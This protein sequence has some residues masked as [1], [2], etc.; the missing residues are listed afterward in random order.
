[1]QQQVTV[2]CLLVSISG[3][4]ANLDLPGHMERIVW[5][6]LK[7]WR[8]SERL[9]IQ[10]KEDV[11]NCI[12]RS[13]EICTHYQFR[14]KW[15]CQ[16]GQDETPWV[17]DE[18]FKQNFSWKVRMVERCSLVHTDEDD[19]SKLGNVCRTFCRIRCVIREYSKSRASLLAF[20]LTWVDK[21][22]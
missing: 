5:Q 10:G 1:M 2:L 7:T 13:F 3:L 9:N 21:Y 16:E 17:L 20:A 11:E 14:V 8:R 18:K 19:I 15:I 4:C 22:V 12:V 6:C